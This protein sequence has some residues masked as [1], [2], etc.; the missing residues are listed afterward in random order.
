MAGGAALIAVG[1]PTL[2]RPTVAGEASPIATARAVLNLSPAEAEERRRVELPNAVVTAFDPEMHVTFVQDGTAGVYL[3]SLQ[4]RPAVNVGD[5]VR[6]VG[7][8]G[9]GKRE[10]TIERA[11]VERVGSGALPVPICLAPP[12]YRDGVADSQWVEVEGVLRRVQ[13]TQARATL[14][15]VRSDVRFAALVANIQNGALPAV[16]SRLRVRGVLGGGYNAKD[17]LI[18]RRVFV[19]SL[20][21]ID[22]VVE[23]AAAGHDRL[24]SIA[25]A[26]AGTLEYQPAVRVRGTVRHVDSAAAVLISD[27]RSEIVVHSS[28]VVRLTPGDLVEVLGF[29]ASST[30]RPTLEDGRISLVVGNRLVDAPPLE[31]R[32]IAEILAMKAAARVLPYSVRLRAQVLFTNPR[33]APTPTV[34]VHDG[35]AALFV[36]APE[37]IAHLRLGDWVEIEGRTGPTSRSVFVGASRVTVVGHD[38]LPPATPVAADAVMIERYESRWVELHGVVRRATAREDGVEL[39]FGTSAA[40]LFAYVRGLAPEVAAGLVDAHIRLRGV[41]ESTW[42]RQRWTGAALYV[43]G[44]SELAVV[45]PPPGRPW[46]MPVSTVGDLPLMLRSDYD[47]RRVRLR[48]VVTLRRPGDAIWIADET[49]GIEVQSREDIDVQ[50]GDEVEVLGFPIVSGSAAA[51]AEAI[52]RKHGKGDVAQTPVISLGQ[53]LNGAYDAELVQMEGTLLDQASHGTETTLVLQEGR[54]IFTAQLPSAVPNDLN[55]LRTDSRLRLTGVCRVNEN[56]GGDMAGFTLLLRSGDDVAVLR[57]PSPWTRPRVLGLVASLIVLAAGGFGWVMLL[58]R[59]VRAQTEAMRGQL[60]EI[61]AARTHAEQA[62]D[63]LEAT[64]RQLETAIAQSRELAGAAQAASKAKTEF[65]ANMSHEIRT[66]MNGVLGM[67]ELALQT[68]L[69]PEQREYLELAHL[70]AESLLHVID[71]ILDFSKMEADRLEIR[72]EPLEPLVL[73]DEILRSFEIRARQKGLLLER[74]VAAGSPAVIVADGARVRQVLV[75]LVGNAIKFTEQGSVVVEVSPKSAGGGGLA[76]R[77]AVRDTGVGIPAG[78]I[79]LIFEPFA[80]ADGS[81]SRRYGGTGLGLSISTRLVELMG[82]TLE[83]ESD[84]GRGSSFSFTLPVGEEAGRLVD[85]APSRTT[86]QETM[87]RHV[88]VVEDN[89]V[90]L[91]LVEAILCK[92]G[93]TLVAAH[94]GRQAL[95]ILDRE[96]FDAV[97]MDVQMPEMNGIETTE[98]IRARERSVADGAHAPLESCYAAGR[99]GGII[100]V[101]MTAHALEQDRKACLRAGMNAFLGKPIS[102][103]ELLSVIAALESRAPSL[104]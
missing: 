81:I 72:P 28:D 49:G 21:D 95:E 77:F 76:L 99:P 27:G 2:G 1:I 94:T 19:P 74:R 84:E 60:V 80:Q 40:T 102:R 58:R 46:E 25:D 64:N 90:N 61:D 32:S 11:H 50:P 59:R 67:T 33:Q 36:Y 42:S 26:L 24:T 23:D 39:D 79:G 62:N 86:P 69:N 75:N 103:L 70:S 93:H 22:T 83:V 78:K 54:T 10:R 89:P 31:F 8:T 53:A 5:R 71:D 41:A 44:P 82:G 38:R 101:A 13:R 52:V 57:A 55:R 34:Y 96:C 73:I 20:T 85:I 65:V 9:R 16:G 47:S 48:G 43:P 92:A 91:R 66:P 30:A 4:N 51:I 97:L 98:A 17:R 63:Q 15:L 45:S 12:Q 56:R 7:V 88:L 37:D 29:P 104:P 3:D 18:E 87:S 35:T 6:V 68:P 100:I 14:H